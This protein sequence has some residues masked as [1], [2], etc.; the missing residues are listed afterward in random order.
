[1]S[2]RRNGVCVI[3]ILMKS[4]MFD[5]YLY[6][7]DQV[8]KYQLFVFQRLYTIFIIRD[9]DVTHIGRRRLSLVLLPSVSLKGNKDLFFNWT[10][11]LASSSAH[12]CDVSKGRSQASW[13][14]RCLRAS[15]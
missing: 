12:T 10:I 11:R 2:K 1:M 9:G 5:F 15:A 6:I 13:P 14:T 4:E 3:F 8:V 7:L